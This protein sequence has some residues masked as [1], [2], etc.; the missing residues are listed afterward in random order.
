VFNPLII[1]SAVIGGGILV[2][3]WWN[4][5]K[6]DNAKTDKEKFFMYDGYFKYYSGIYGVPYEWFK[7]ISMQESNLGQNQKVK[8]GL[9]SYDG[10]SY[11]IMQIATG[12]GSPKERE[13]KTM[14]GLP[15]KRITDMTIIEKSFTQDI[16]NDADKSISIAGN[17]L[18]YLAK[19]YNYDKD[20][21]FL[22][23]N[24]GERNTD[25][26]KNYTHPNGRYAIIINENLTK[27]KDKEVYYENVVS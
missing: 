21:V 13:L 6:I 3:R 14:F 16:L 25:N 22:A 17:L 24:Q 15:D 18:G 2:F 20:K 12:T 9:V 19:K 7:A 27:I 1:G 23:Y 11:G 5:M 4:D 8:Q 26:G 10:L